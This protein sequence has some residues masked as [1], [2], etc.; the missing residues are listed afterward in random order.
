MPT[1]VHEVVRAAGWLDERLVHVCSWT[2][3][4]VL[5]G[6]AS[7]LGIDD[8]A[9]PDA[10]PDAV[11]ADASP[12][13][14]FDRWMAGTIQLR[15][16]TPV[17]VFATSATERDP[18][19]TPGGLYAATTAFG[20]SFDI[21]FS[22]LRAGAFVAPIRID[23]LSSA[24]ADSK[25]A[26]G[27]D[28]TI[29]ATERSGGSGASDLWEYRGG[30]FSQ[31]PFVN[32]NTPAAQ[33]DPWVSSDG[34]ALLYSATQSGTQVIVVSTRSSFVAPFAAPFVVPGI[35]TP[36]ADPW[37]SADS[38]LL[39]FASNGRLFYARRT[40]QDPGFSMATAIPD[41]D[42]GMQEADPVLSDDGCTLYFSSNRAGT[43]DIF[44]AEVE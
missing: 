39:L 5:G 26:F 8:F 34:M 1:Q 6:C 35:A 21:G 33:F 16:A 25:V 10:A 18:T 23:A 9:P 13:T 31:A 38:T 17:A 11:S 4:F 37:V 28:T 27:A 41:V 14:C 12:R 19:V 15:P 7:L 40:E 2:T 29:I 20:M 43:F 30:T 42:S 36:S 44:R 24:Q 32:V 22:E 3:I